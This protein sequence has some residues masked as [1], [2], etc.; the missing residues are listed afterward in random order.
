MPTATVNNEQHSVADISIGADSSEL[1][2]SLLRLWQVAQ[3][4]RKT[5]LRAV[6]ISAILGAL[7]FVF[8]PRYYDSTAKLWIVHRNQD[9]VASVGDEPVLDNTM[10]NQREIV[11]SPVVVQQAIE[12]LLPEHRL[13]FQDSPPS[14]WSTILAKG[15]SAR[16][17]RKTNIIEI[18]YRS[19]SP[20]A[21]SAVASAVIQSYLQFV[22]RTHKGSANEVIAAL[23]QDRDKIT[24]LLA[25]KQTE[26]QAT[27][28]RV[29][30][31]PVQS[32]EGISDPTI[33]A[34]LQL[35]NGL[36]ETK[37]KRLKLQGLVV[38]I[39]QAIR[40]GDD[41]QQYIVGME[42]IVGRQMLIS[43]LGISPQDMMLINTQQQKLL[44][45][46]SE[47]QKTA[48]FYGPAHPKVV[49]LQERIQT[50]QQYLATYRADA[51]QR[52]A[53]FGGSDLGPLLQKMLE[54]SVAQTT[55]EEEQLQTAFNEARNVAVQQSAEIMQLQNLERDVRRLEEQQDILIQKM[56]N[57]D[58]EH[59]RAPIQA[60]VV[61]EPLPDEKPDSPKLRLVFMF[62]LMAGLF[63]G[64]I[65]AYVQDVLDDR[66]A[67][68]EEM[69]AQLGVPVLS[70]VRRMEPLEG[71]GLATVQT[72]IAPNAVE[73]EA[74]RT[75]RT[76]LTLGTGTTDR[77]AISSAEPGDG[78]TTV[79]ANLAVSFAQAGKRTLIIDAD[80]RKPGMTAL[81]G[82]KGQPGL[83]DVLC[84]HENP[85]SVAPSLIRHTELATLDVLPAGL[86]RPN[87]AELLS[88]PNF[89][90]LLAWAE[91]TY[92][93]VLVDCP[94]VL[95]VSDAQIIGRLLDGA[96]L[97]VQPQKN[98]RRLV[99]RACY[100]FTTTGTNVLGVVA[101]GLSPQSGRGYGYGYGYGYSYGYGHGHETDAA[102]PDHAEHFPAQQNTGA[103]IGQRSDRAA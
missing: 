48:P 33:Q 87:P 100:S 91:S 86:R 32:D 67:S 2:H 59:F 82:L 8:A 78:K 88:A 56:H 18:R 6:C 97:V 19:L 3:Y 65:V 94:P 7:Y 93:Q 99:A 40:S 77:I 24:Q 84:G 83:A 73:T 58:V 13:D 1:V 37:R 75:L 68:P 16:T 81:M 31:L 103:S 11:V 53:S 5:I 12:Y 42:E 49:E 10:A 69:S 102:P 39:E 17:T 63:V 51:G 79:S 28:Q 64:G 57:I 80:L 96:I 9:Q 23:S 44:E 30:H 36:L 71:T 101:N 70:M 22:D 45:A 41:L 14:E 66:F 98:H 43:A 60:T 46:Q 26:L 55:H 38:S 35:Y 21:A 74:F 54:Q 85:A 47:L 29:G 76:A 34:A 25:A 15:L 20:E 61:Q 92:E 4:R 27:L 90:E 89:V 62:S 52:L 95:A 72:F 50:I